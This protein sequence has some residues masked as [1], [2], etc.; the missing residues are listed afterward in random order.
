[1]PCMPAF[2]IRER[3]GEPTLRGYEDAGPVRAEALR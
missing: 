2:T 1:M 3:R